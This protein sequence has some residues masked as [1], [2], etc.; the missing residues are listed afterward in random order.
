MK[1]FLNR[2]DPPQAIDNLNTGLKK[3]SFEDNMD[4]F[5]WSGKIAAG[6]E[7]K[8]QNQFRDGFPPL[9]FVVTMVD[10]VN[11]IG[12]G[13]SPWTNK[14]VFLKN[15]HSADLTIEVYFFK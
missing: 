2:A 10:G 9:R 11:G 13:P 1:F 12:K 14:A 6:A 4:S 8:I 5:V 15:Y 3:L 7:T